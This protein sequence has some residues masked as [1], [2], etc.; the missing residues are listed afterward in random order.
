MTNKLTPHEID[1]L[2]TECFD[3]HEALWSEDDSGGGK[4]ANFAED[5]MLWEHA[6]GAISD[7]ELAQRYQTYKDNQK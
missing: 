3:R 2:V 5:M 4:A 6:L 7:E 1:Q